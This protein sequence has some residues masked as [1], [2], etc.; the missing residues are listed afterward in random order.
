MKRK[1]KWKWILDKSKSH[2]SKWTKAEKKCQKVRTRN[3]ESSH[4]KA[5]RKVLSSKVQSVS[6]LFKWFLITLAKNHKAVS[7]NIG[8]NGTGFLAP[9]HVQS[10]LKD[11]GKLMWHLKY[12][13]RLSAFE[14]TENG[15]FY[16]VVFPDNLSTYK[17]DQ[18]LSIK[19]NSRNENFIMSLPM[20]NKCQIKKKRKTTNWGPWSKC[21]DS[22]CDTYLAIKIRR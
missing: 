13:S 4:E 8:P 22:S 21:L 2:H 15:I 20:R 9:S 17:N 11:P 12:R 5:R 18:K 3:D 16:K 10:I 7:R 1:F 19:K 6:L 14:T